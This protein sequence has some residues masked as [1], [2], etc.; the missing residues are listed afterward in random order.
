MK[1]NPADRQTV[2]ET[3]LVTTMPRVLVVSLAV[4]VFLADRGVKAWMV[5]HL[6][7]GQT[8]GILPPI[9]RV[10]LFENSGAAFSLLPNHQWLFVLVAGGVLAGGAYGLMSRTRLRKIPGAAIGLVMGGTTGNLWDR[11]VNARV[12]DY[13]HVEH[14]PIFNLADSA[15]VVGMFLLLWDGWHRE[16]RKERSGG[17][18]HPLRRRRVSSRPDSPRPAGDEGCEQVPVRSDGAYKR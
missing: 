8:I 11:L 6:R 10:T 9:L 17:N 18:G 16:T 3:G 4:G 15:I 2:D 5:H 7:P 14:F 13:I 1:E 12:I